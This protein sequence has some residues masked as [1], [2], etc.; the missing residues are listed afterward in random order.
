MENTSLEYINSNLLKCIEE[1]HKKKILLDKEISEAAEE[2]KN[3]E[4][5]MEILK[6]RHIE[7]NKYLECKKVENAYYDTKITETE[8]AYAKICESSKILLNVISPEQ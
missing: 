4:R 2:K 8:N 6:N 3:L 5:D 1:I 7:V